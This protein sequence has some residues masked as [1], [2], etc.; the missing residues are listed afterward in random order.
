MSYHTPVLV[1]ETVE[2]LVTRPGGWFV[3]GTVGGGGHAA[4]ILTA[5][6]PGGRVLGLDWDDDALSAAGDRLREF[7]NQVRLVRANYRELDV[8]LMREGLTAVDGVL[9]D[10]GVSA[11]Q[12]DAPERGFSLQRPGP[13]DMRMDRRLARTAHDLL[14]HG[15]LDELT[16]IFRAYGEERRSRAVATAIVRQRQ[17]VGPLETT[18]ELAGLAERVLGRGRRIHPATRVFQALRIAVNDE[19]GNLRRALPAAVAALRQGGRLAVISFHSL[20]DR[21]IKRFFAESSRGCVCP[22]SV[23]VCACGHRATLRTITRKPVVA[24]AVEV[25]ANPRARSAKLRVA[26]KL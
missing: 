19:L 18:T 22:P 17:R 11:H 2:R 23:P 24:A 9:L 21:I 3:D 16:D 15:E 20:E 5:S 7:G 4:A 12:F 1:R 13:L 6:G 26:E 25:A 14:A 8:V 10:L